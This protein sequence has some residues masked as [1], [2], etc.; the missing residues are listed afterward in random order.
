MNRGLKLLR[1]NWKKNFN[2]FK[3]RQKCPHSH[4]GLSADGCLV[5]YFCKLDD[6][7]CSLGFDGSCINWVTG[8]KRFVCY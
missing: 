4:K 3:V 6:C 2:P 7:R 1:Q 5:I 8:K